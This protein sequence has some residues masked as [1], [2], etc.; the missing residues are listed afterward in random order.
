[1]RTAEAARGRGVAGA[2]LAALVAHARERGWAALLLETGTQPF[3]APATRLYLR[4]G[5]APRGPFGAYRVDP[6]SRYLELRL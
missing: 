1:M 4:H 2:V 3:F 5:F 6:N